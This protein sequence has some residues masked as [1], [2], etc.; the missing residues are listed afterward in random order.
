MGG[1]GSSSTDLGTGG[2]HIGGSNTGGGSGGESASTGGKSSGG[3]GTGGANSGGDGG[4]GGGSSGGSEAG[5]SSSGGNGSGGDAPSADA[6]ITVWNTDPEP[7]YWFEGV[8][9]PATSETTLILPLVEEGTYD[10]SV[11]WGDG[12]SSTITSPSDADAVHEYSEPGEYTVVMEGTIEGWAF[13]LEYTSTSTLTDAVKL[14][15]I[16]Q[17]GAFR[18]GETAGAFRAA[19]HLVV[20]AE[21]A[22][23]LS[24]PTTL[25]SAFSECHALGNAGAFGSWD[26]SEV[27]STAGMFNGASTFDQDISAWNVSAVTDMSQMFM[28]TEF[29]QDISGW[30][31]S[32]VTTMEEMFY[33]AMAFDQDLRDWDVSNVTNMRWM[34][35]QA[36]AF[37]GDISTWQTSNVNSMRSMFA[38]ARSFNQDIAGWDVSAVNNMMSLFFGANTFDQDLSAWDVS[39]VTNMTNMFR[40]ATA[41]DQD[42]SEWDISALTNATDMLTQSGVSSANYS[43][44]LVGWAAQTTESDVPL[45]AGSIQYTAAA[46]MAR[47]VLTGRG[48]TIADGGLAP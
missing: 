37:D 25:V 44:L 24:A 34:F 10:F 27:T 41:F 1:G 43:A 47:G 3:T 20:G 17:W 12:T 21:D 32:A 40:N 18:F 38:D 35:A 30:D 29:N 36:T 7:F 42:L 13:D 28:W 11:S 46:Q 8:Y 9:A 5:G 45:G 48:W 4:L 23:D 39:S 2:Q 6:F 33:A 19:V 14:S 26:L 22:P 15:R 16:E 31:V